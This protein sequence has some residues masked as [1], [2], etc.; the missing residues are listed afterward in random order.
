MRWT[1]CCP[2]VTSPQ[3]IQWCTFRVSI[4]SGLASN[5]LKKFI[6]FQNDWNNFCWSK[7][8]R[9][10][11]Q[12]SENI[13]FAYAYVLQ[14]CEKSALFHS[15]RKSSL[16]VFY[17]IWKW[18]SCFM[19]FLSILRASLILLSILINIIPHYLGR[20]PVKTFLFL[21]TIWTIILFY[22]FPTCHLLGNT[23]IAFLPPDL[24]IGIIKFEF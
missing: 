1:A 6:I 21:K 11:L 12:G 18:R 23:S 24:H 22:M 4:S 16:N 10:D 7:Y 9:G 8:E 20:S 13:W 17:Q 19:P 14:L 15:R 3:Q 5:P 2:R